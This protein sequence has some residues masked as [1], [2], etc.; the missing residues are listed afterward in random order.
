MRVLD[1]QTGLGHPLLNTPYVLQQSSLSPD[2]KKLIYSTG[3]ANFNILELSLD[4]KSARPLVES[5]LQNTNPNWS[6]KDGSLVYVRNYATTSEIWTRSADGLRNTLLVKSTRG[7]QSLSSP[8]FSPDGRS[9]AYADAGSLFTILADGGRAVEIFH[10]KA[11]EVIGPDWSPRGD[12]I[13]FIDRVG[14]N[15]KILR[16]AP[17][18]GATAT[19]TDNAVRAFFDIR[20]SPDGRWLACSTLDEVRLISPDGKDEHQ[21][22]NDVAGGDFSRDGKTY[23][24]VRRD[25]NGH[26]ILLPIDVAAG[27]EGSVVA[28]PISGALYASGVSLN[29]DGKHIAI[30]VNDLKYDLWMIEGFPRP[31]QGLARLWKNWQYP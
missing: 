26:W 12:S 9:V 29:P 1:T 20:W 13:A 11:G 14:S 6:L 17:S 8:R 19:V 7:A 16:V 24:D 30:H 3:N 28:L 23:Y 18:G 5:S 25:D 10:D 2:G 31:A 22:T 21:L 4:G 27:R 15:Y